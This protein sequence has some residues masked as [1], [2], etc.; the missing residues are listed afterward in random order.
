MLAESAV[1]T[2]AFVLPPGYRIVDVETARDGPQA[3]SIRYSDGTRTIEVDGWVR[4]P[5]VS[6]ADSRT[7]AQPIVT[8]ARAPAEV[9]MAQTIPLPRAPMPR[10]PMPRPPYPTLPREVVPFSEGRSYSLPAARPPYP[11]PGNRLPSFS[12][13]V[14]PAPLGQSSSL[15]AASFWE[16]PALPVPTAVPQPGLRILVDSKLLGKTALRQ[17]YG[18]EEC[19]RTIPTVT[20]STWFAYRVVT[21]HVGLYSAG[22]LIESAR[23]VRP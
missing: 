22:Q 18:N 10:A 4:R 20:L 15:P 19:F 21:C 14:A 23:V 9:I 8:F 13:P 3:Y 6:Q 17:P 5:G 12:T 16:G 1:P 11:T 7:P 2:V